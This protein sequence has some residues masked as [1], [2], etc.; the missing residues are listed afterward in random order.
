M[1]VTSTAEVLPSFAV[2]LGAYQY[3]HLNGQNNEPG[4]HD[5]ADAIGGCVSPGPEDFRA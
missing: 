4:G 5:G 2:T 1:F 3:D